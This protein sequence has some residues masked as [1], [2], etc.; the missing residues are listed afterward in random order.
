M[1]E[2]VPI[3]RNLNVINVFRNWDAKANDETLTDTQEAVDDLS[4]ASV[5]DCQVWK[6]FRHY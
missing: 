3:D 1:Q 4:G 5:F 6:S 2:L